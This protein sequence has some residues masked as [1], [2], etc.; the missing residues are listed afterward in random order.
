[1]NTTVLPDGFNWTLP[2]TA[3]NDTAHRF[4]VDE[5]ADPSAEVERALL[6]L[7]Q[8]S[9]GSPMQSMI[10]EHL[11]AGGR[12]LRARL[13]LDVA[14]CG[15]ATRQSAVW[16]AAA[17]EMMHNATLVHD[18]LQDGDVVRRGQPALWATYGSA[19]A[20]NAGDAMLM[21]PYA[22]IWRT[23]VPADTASALCECLSRRT[24]ATACGQSIELGLTD[25]ADTSWDAYI[26]AAWGKTG[27][28]FAMPVEGA[29]LCAGSSRETAF[30]VADSFGWVGVLF[31]IIDDVVDLYGE[32]GRGELGADV[33]EGKLSAL[34]IQHLLRCPEEEEWLLGILREDRDA[35]TAAQVSQV[36]DRFEQSGALEAT[37]Q[38]IRHGRV[39]IET[40]PDLQPYPRLREF[41]IGVLDSSAVSIHDR[42]AATSVDD[43]L[44]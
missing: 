12:R 35:T 30:R 29:L 36:R 27:Q 14:L 26:Q 6:L 37:L 24:V 39:F 33:K 7:T 23:G 18:D 43:R 21:M 17:C 13:A 15:G 20:I 10:T 34:V 11:S 2:S 25:A 28:F 8:L 32:K 41:G 9:A 42:L 19:Q 40:H 16:W 3:P 31:Q 38:L 22:A 4:A 1:M 44:M 5:S